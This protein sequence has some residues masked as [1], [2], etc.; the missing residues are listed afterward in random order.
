M[1]TRT[2][3]ATSGSD[4]MPRSHTWR[5][6]LFLVVTVALVIPIFAHGCHGDDVDHEPSVP[7]N[8]DASS[9]R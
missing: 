9:R 7:V 3:F 6:P 8:P 1:T 5:I 4:R 2:C